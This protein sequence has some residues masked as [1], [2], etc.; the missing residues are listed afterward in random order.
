[1]VE[2]VDGRAMDGRRMPGYTIC[3]AMSLKVQ[4]SLKSNNIGHANVLPYLTLLLKRSRSAQGNHL[5]KLGYT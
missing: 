5:N 3:K 2:N 1:M 4:V